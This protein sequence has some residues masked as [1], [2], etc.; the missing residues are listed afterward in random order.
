MGN[1]F[2]HVSGSGL[3]VGVILLNCNLTSNYLTLIPE[4]AEALLPSDYCPISLIHN[5]AKFFD[6][7]GG[8]AP[9]RLFFFA[10]LLMKNSKEHQKGR[11]SANKT[12][13][14]KPLI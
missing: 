4:K 7:T 12:E 9:Y 10:F 11:Q 8:V 13:Q 6:E 1:Y 3:I 2:C 5:F 14:K